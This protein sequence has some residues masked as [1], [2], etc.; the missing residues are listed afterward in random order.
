MISLMKKHN[1]SAMKLTLKNLR[2]VNEL[3]NQVAPTNM[4]ATRRR[5]SR[6]FQFRKLIEKN[7][8]LLLLRKLCV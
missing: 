4:N 7:C 2:S 1:I 8:A 3:I 6:R 5:T